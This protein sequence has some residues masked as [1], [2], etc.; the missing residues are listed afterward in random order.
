[1]ATLKAPKT[2]SKRK[3]LR[4]DKAVT[5]FVRI[6]EFLYNNR[7]L[8]Y[9]I[10]GAFVVVLIAIGGYAFWQSQ[11][12]DEAQ[13]LLGSIVRIYEE[14]GYR[15]ALDGVG[16]TPGLLTIAGDYGSSDAGNLA[17]FYAADALFRLGEYDQALD[18]F[19]A[20]DK[21]DNIVGA[22]ALAGE[23]AIHEIQGNYGRAGDLYERAATVYDDELT[24]P[25]YLHN[26]G[27]SYEKA[28][29]YEDARDA[30]QR[31][32]DQYPDSNQAQSIDFFLARVSAKIQ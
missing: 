9:G 18:Y 25:G 23:A 7:T 12:G 13:A 10:A 15:E 26:A 2:I 21:G 16:D 22:S 28:E 32:R 20:F 11:R 29:Q 27:R 14:G 31:I 5:V 1:M 8:A 6:Q 3:E 19:E 30:Y 4:Q 24:S 17:R